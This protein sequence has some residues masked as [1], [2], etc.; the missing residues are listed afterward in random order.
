MIKI[1]K[2]V[3]AII[4]ALEKGDFYCSQGPEIKDVYVQDGKVHITCSDAKEIYLATGIRRCRVA[5]AKKG[6]YINSASFPLVDKMRYIRLEVV[7]ENQ[8]SAY[9][10]AYFTD[11][12]Q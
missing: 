7:D 11:E 12:W 3:K 4:E 2:E 8:K 10:R 1:P 5:R 6:E 9:T